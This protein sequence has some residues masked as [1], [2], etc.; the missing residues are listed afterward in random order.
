MQGRLANRGKTSGRMISLRGAM[1][2]HRAP[3][4]HVQ[5]LL[6]T[7]KGILNILALRV[8]ISREAV[9][10]GSVQR[11]PVQ[12]VVLRL[13]MHPMRLTNVHVH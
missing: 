11:I 8:D 9:A 13:R 6:R 4:R 2:A 1:A 5:M 3:L 12:Y 10:P 7:C